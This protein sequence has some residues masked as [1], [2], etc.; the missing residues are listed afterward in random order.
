MVGEGV[1][2]ALRVHH[3]IRS[4]EAAGI[5][6]VI[7]AQALTRL[8]ED[9]V[10]IAGQLIVQ[11]AHAAL[12]IFGV[13]GRLAKMFAEEHRIVA[14]GFGVEAAIAIVVVFNIAIVEDVAAVAVHVIEHRLDGADIAI[15]GG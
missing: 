8:A 1:V 12:E 10:Q 5:A 9:V 6:L 15:R 14:R 13:T 7:A 3:A 11:Q 2:V 4:A